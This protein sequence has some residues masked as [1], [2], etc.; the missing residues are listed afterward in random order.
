VDEC[1]KT[2]LPACDDWTPVV[3]NKILLRIVAIASGNIFLGP[4]LCRRE[5]YLHAS[6]NYT[7]DVFA[8]VRAL[9]KWPKVIR[10][11]ARYFTP[12]LN[13]IKEHK[14]KARK[15]LIPI[16]HER[17]VMMTHGREMPDD[18]LQWML[19]KSAHYDVQDDGEIASIQLTL[20][21]AAIHT[22][23]M[24]A[25]HMYVLSLLVLRYTDSLQFI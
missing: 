19:N 18:M 11:V 25:T 13:R 7:I 4:E 14:E 2:E 16:I 10:P 3:I 12:Q 15:F 6:I 23:S 20:S 8:A 1:V 17:K 5:E 21:M 24:T 22:T 9:K